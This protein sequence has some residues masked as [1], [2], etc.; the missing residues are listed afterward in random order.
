[1]RRPRGPGGRF[2]IAAE[3]EAAA[4]GKYGGQNIAGEVADAQAKTAEQAVPA[5]EGQ[6]LL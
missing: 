5:L 4:K 6:D 2:L 1:M 3:M